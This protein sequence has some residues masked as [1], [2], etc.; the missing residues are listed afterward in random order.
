M[1]ETRPNGEASTPESLS[2]VSSE[3]LHAKSSPSQR[4]YKGSKYKIRV[5]PQIDSNS[6]GG[7]RCRYWVSIVY[8]WAVGGVC[9]LL[10]GICGVVMYH[11]YATTF[12]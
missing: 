8:R 10:C 1:E 9:A 5:G 12:V 7:S 11:N 6:L 4:Q 2:E 3:K